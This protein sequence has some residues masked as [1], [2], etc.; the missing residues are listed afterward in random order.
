M[1]Y[2]HCSVSLERAA[3]IS[4]DTLHSNQAHENTSDGGPSRE[5]GNPK[6]NRGV[7]WNGDGTVEGGNVPGTLKLE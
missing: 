1:I 5:M 2:N 4:A 3:A 7:K 6:E